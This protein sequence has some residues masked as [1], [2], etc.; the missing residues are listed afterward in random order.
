MGEAH[1]AE[2][3]PGEGSVPAFTLVEIMVVVALLSVI[4]LGLMAMFTQTQRAFRTGM[5]QTEVMEGGRMA[6]DMLSRELEQ[7]TPCYLYRS[8]TQPDNIDYPIPNFEAET[9]RLL[10]QPLPGGDG[11]RQRTNVLCDVFFMFRQ[12]QTWTGIGYFVRTNRLDD[13]ALP[14]GFGPVG[15]LFRFETNNSL[16]QFEQN[17]GALYAGF[18]LARNNL[19]VSNGVSRVLDGVI[20]FRIRPFDLSGWVLTNNPTYASNEFA[21]LNCPALVRTNL[22][23]NP[24]FFPESGE[25]GLYSF[26]SNA[27]PA[28]VEVELGMLEQRAYEQ[29]KSLPTPI[30]RY[31]YLTNELTGVISK[32]HVFRQN[33][34][35]RNVDPSAYR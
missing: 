26:F 5:A 1:R 12:N 15:T 4:V 21:W 18:N 24:F 17:P 20:H 13:P 25:I 30:A 34:P 7:V 35:V 9:L 11:L 14:G 33:I 19:T 28:S 31:R 2:A 10:L 16:S 22:I 3:G 27:V 32:V 23:L 6:T 8:N 29:Y